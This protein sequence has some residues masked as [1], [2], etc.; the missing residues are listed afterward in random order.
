VCMCGRDLVIVLWWWGCGQ[1]VMLVVLLCRYCD[2]Y[3][4]VV[5]VL[6]VMVF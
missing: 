2:A 3:V 6:G 4:V 5:L 1:L